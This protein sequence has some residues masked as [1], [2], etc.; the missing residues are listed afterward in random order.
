MSGASFGT[1]FII[2]QATG[3]DVGRE[4]IAASPVVAT[5]FFVVLA[6]LKYITGR[7]K[8]FTEH[9]KNRDDIFI[10]YLKGRDEVHLQTSNRLADAIDR[11]EAKLNK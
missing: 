6:F 3:Q 10:S 11:L 5:L 7:D 1:I 9:Q 2:A 8:S 4:L